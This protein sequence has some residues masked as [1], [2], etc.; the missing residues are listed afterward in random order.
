MSYRKPEIDGEVIA[1]P[2]VGGVEIQRNQIHSANFKRTSR[3]NATGTVIT[4]KA[5]IKMSFSP[6]IT[7]AE[8][9]LI[10]SK[11]TDKTAFHKFGFTNE[12]GE[13]EEKTVY[14]NNYSISQYAFINGKMLN[15]SISFEAVEK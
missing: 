7:K 6:K 3:G 13:W 5:S 11:T 1:S 14:F 15:Q 8:L 9:K 4:N 2:S 12:F 10:K